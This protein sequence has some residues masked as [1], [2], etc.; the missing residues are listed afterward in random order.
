MLHAPLFGRPVPP[1]PPP[2]VLPPFTPATYI[3]LRRRASRLTIEQA[4]E[5][6]LSGAIQVRPRKMGRSAALAELRELLRQLETPGVVARSTDTLLL[7]RLAFPFDPD[8]Y[9]QLATE[10]ADRHPR[11]C[12][13]CGCSQW[14]PCRHAHQRPCAWAGADICTHCTDG[15]IL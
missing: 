8:V 6:I 12:R 15:E 5:R 7:V 10:P 11:I 4:A 14:D 3:A 13:G 2:G 9:C 1:P